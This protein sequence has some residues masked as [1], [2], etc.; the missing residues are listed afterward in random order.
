MLSG[1]TFQVWHVNIRE[2]SS[3]F[4]CNTDVHAYRADVTHS[5]HH[6]ASTIRCVISCNRRI[7]CYIHSPLQMPLRVR[8]CGRLEHNHRRHTFV[9]SSKLPLI[10]ASATL[11]PRSTSTMYRF[12]RNS[13]VASENRRAQ[14]VL[15]S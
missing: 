12:T 6:V 2:C 14:I 8:W 7:L 3:R 1:P 5:R 10:N 13:A 15:S 4:T 11:S 9:V